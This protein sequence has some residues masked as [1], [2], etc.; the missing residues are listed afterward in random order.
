LLFSPSNPLFIPPG[1]PFTHSRWL[2]QLAK[3]SFNEQKFDQAIILTIL[4]LDSKGFERN[5]F[6]FSEFIRSDIKPAIPSIWLVK[7]IVWI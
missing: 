1:P 7:A 2:E 5:L 6:L 3:H 4:I